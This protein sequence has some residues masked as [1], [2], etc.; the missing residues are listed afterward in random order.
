MIILPANYHSIHQQIITLYTEYELL[1]V[2]MGVNLPL[3]KHTEN[4]ICRKVICVRVN[5]N[6]WLTEW[7]HYSNLCLKLHGNYKPEVAT[8]SKRNIQLKAT[9]IG[10]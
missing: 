4:E 3:N 7:L 1:V 6:L 8:K 10:S 5:T 9:I 2:L